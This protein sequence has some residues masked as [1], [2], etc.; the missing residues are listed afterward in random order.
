VYEREQQR[1]RRA[2]SEER[3]DKREERREVKEETEDAKKRAMAY[4]GSTTHLQTL[5]E[6]TTP[7]AVG[8]PHV[9]TAG[10]DVSAVA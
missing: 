5:V 10:P 1:E 9:G 6:E 7:G 4:G 8:I 3:G 2:K